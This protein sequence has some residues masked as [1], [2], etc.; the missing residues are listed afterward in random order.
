MQDAVV[1]KVGRQ[2]SAPVVSPTFEAKIWTNMPKHDDMR[3]T[4]HRA[5]P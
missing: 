3:R 5:Y 1:E 4:Q 2:G